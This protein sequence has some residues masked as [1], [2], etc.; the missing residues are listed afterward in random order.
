MRTSRI[1]FAVSAVSLLAACAGAPVPNPRHPVAKVPP[2][3]PKASRALVA[4]GMRDRGESTAA[5]LLTVRQVG[6]V[7][8]DR[9]YV[10]DIAQNEYVMIDVKPGPHEIACS[11][12]EPVHN[13]IEH[14]KIV[15]EPG[16][17]KTLVCDMVTARGDLGGNY[18]SKTYVEPRG[19][20]TE[21]GAV[22]EYKKIP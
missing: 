15:F 20:N 3:D 10:G 9:K 1:V 2:L 21:N 17:T 18:S 22:V 8:V 5:T 14:R 12:L 16:E 4:S 13:Y 7:Y 6:P 11:P 19:I